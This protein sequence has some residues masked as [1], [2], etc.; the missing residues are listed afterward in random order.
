MD[1]GHKNSI[2]DLWTDTA[3]R[4]LIGGAVSGVKHGQRDRLSDYNQVNQTTSL[5]VERNKKPSSLL[6][7]KR[8]YQELSKSPNQTWLSRRSSEIVRAGF[9]LERKP[10]E[11][12]KKLQWAPFICFLHYFKV[13]FHCHKLCGNVQ[14]VCC[15]LLFY[16]YILNDY[17]TIT[18]REQ[19]TSAILYVSYAHTNKANCNLTKRQEERTGRVQEKGSESAGSTARWWTTVINELQANS[20]SWNQISNQS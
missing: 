17:V 16:C 15:L 7:L 8:K 10:A 6:D 1:I 11:H 3:E 14:T 5:H 2:S 19:P 13:F 4:Q 20:E 9:Q 18:N 12:H